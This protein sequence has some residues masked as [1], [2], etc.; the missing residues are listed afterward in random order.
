MGIVRENYH[1]KNLNM[2]KA[3]RLMELYSR[4]IETSLKIYLERKSY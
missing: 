1:D 3:Q 4:Q 2:V